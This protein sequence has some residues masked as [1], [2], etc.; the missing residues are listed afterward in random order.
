MRIKPHPGEML[1]EEFLKPLDMSGRAL[2]DAI[3]VP[4][5][6]IND[7]LRARRGVSADTAIRLGKYFRTSPE[8]W[9][10]MQAAHELSKAR[11]EHAKDYDRVPEHA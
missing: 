9:L 8:M 10:N 11:A 1:R 5:N 7:I 6:R 3:G 4:H 2:A